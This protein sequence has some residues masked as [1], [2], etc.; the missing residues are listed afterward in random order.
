[1]ENIFKK[2]QV[3]KEQ[4]KIYFSALLL[5]LLPIV[6]VF[7]RCALDGKMLSDVY[8]PA[9]PWND[10]LFYFKLTEGV[11]SHGVPQGYFG[12]NE[13][14][15][16]LLSFAAWSPILLLFWVIY[17]LL[18]GWNLLSPMIANLLMMSLALFV[19]G[20][21]AKPNK[22]QM[23]LIAV[24]YICFPPVTRFILSCIPEAE[25]FALFILFWGIALNCRR[26]Y[27]G[28]KIGLLFLLVML[29]TW[30]RPYLILLFMTPIWIWIENAPKD[31]KEYLKISGISVAITGVTIAIYGL[32]SYLFSAPYLTDLFYTEWIGKY[33][34]EGF[35]AG[36]KYMVWKLFTSLKSIIEIIGQN[37]RI[38]GEVASAAGLYYV[39]FLLLM[40]ILIWK[41]IYKLFVQKKKM[42]QVLPELQM[43]LCMLG[44]FVADLLMYRLHEGGRHTLVYIVGMVVLLPFM[45]DDTTEQAPPHK[46][47]YANGVLWT[48]LAGGFLFIFVGRGNVPYEFEIP[49]KTIEQETELKSL[50][51][52]LLENMELEEDGIS[53]RNTVIWSLWDTVQSAEGTEKT[54][55]VDFGAYYA[56]PE[57]FGI[58]LCDGGFV[59]VNLENLQSRYIG[60]I[61]GGSFEKR[62]IEAGGVLIG[63]CDSLALYDMK[64]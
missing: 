43:M 36:A 25:L 5:G 62:C 4:L 58:N 8:L 3:N 52:Q 20:I 27:K 49:Y 16:R 19:F 41:L 57:G 10:E 53:Y 13:S 37:L 7:L 56:L 17:G 28:R 48:L 61:P 32:I 33:F 18:F 12:F 31:K 50:S 6:C 38:S 40:S 1:M 47:N 2:G 44:F 29:M 9:S 54:K 30:M 60:I 26:N 39:I 15:G 23:M 21:L 64:P 63:E 22:R 14:H 35:A 46:K 51:A 55:A 34:D 59:D 11:L 42:Y 45:G 24:L